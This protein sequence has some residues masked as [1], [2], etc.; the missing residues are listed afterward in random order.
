MFSPRQ[1]VFLSLFLPCCL[2][3]HPST[4]APSAEDQAVVMLQ[5]PT[6]A[7]LYET[8]AVA[9]GS[10]C[11]YATSKPA[12]LLLSQNPFLQPV[13]LKKREQAIELVNSCDPARIVAEINDDNPDPTI[14]PNMSVSAALDAGLFSQLLWV[15][16]IDS[17][18]KQLSAETFH[19]QL[20]EKGIV[21]QAE[22]ASF[23]QNGNELT[24]M[25]HGVPVRVIPLDK[26]YPLK[27]S[28]LVHLDM[29]F[30][31]PLYQNEIKSPLFPLIFQT[32]HKLRKLEQTPLSVSLSQSNSDGGLPLT[33]RFVGS[34]VQSLFQK[35]EQL[36]RQPRLN[37][38]RHRDALYLDNFFKNEETLSL[39]Q[40]MEQTETDNPDIKYALYQ[41]LRKLKKGTAALEKLAEAVALDPT[42]A[43]EYLSLARTAF[44]LIRPD[45]ALRMFDLAMLTFP[46]NPFI[47]LQ[48]AELLTTLGQQQAALKLLRKLRQLSW[49]DLYYP[50]VPAHLD[51]LIEAAQ[52]PLPHNNID[53]VAPATKA[54]GKTEQ[55]GT[56]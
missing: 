35:P 16:P 4:A 13:P 7:P 37:W 31:P 51:R 55:T 15:L 32:L 28:L 20:V 34:V 1:L 40:Q 2:L 47:G 56:N 5:E 53:A 8:S 12:L 33:T 36:D 14:L 39:Y 10:W 27:N 19:Q 25:L 30:F 52:Q 18:Q 6:E 24:G 54:N 46:Q 9:L 17:S 45:E 50:R 43:L 38:Q 23:I 11:R 48:K 29:S 49:S 3:A 22:A 26:L 42:Y 21:N 44:E 41:N